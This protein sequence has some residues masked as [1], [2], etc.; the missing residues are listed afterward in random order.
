MIDRI[1]MVIFLLPLSAGFVTAQT[2]SYV[3]SDYFN[4]FLGSKYGKIV[5]ASPGI[6]GSP[7]D[8]D[9]FVPGEVFTND[10]KHYTGIPLRYN[11]YSDQMEF[12]NPEGG[13]Y[14][15]NKPE[16]LDSILI[17]NSKFIYHAFITGSKNRCG[18]FKV[19]T[20]GTPSLLLKM[21]V[22]L[23]PAEPAGTYKDA[24]PATYEKGADDFYLLFSQDEAVKFSGKKELFERLS[25]S[26]PEM[27]QFIKKN[28][29]RFNKQEDLIDLM[30]YYY[31]FGK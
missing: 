13:I 25:P 10:R 18:Y 7:Y 6:L 8:K 9:N 19:L 20:E 1:L 16:T 30:N 5:D 26:L 29:I 15:V 27:E 23:N 3:V 17:S 12:R 21:K 11:I 31:S 28:K 24:V 22:T 4:T 14:E 2:S